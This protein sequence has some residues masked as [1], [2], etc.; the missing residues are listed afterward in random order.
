M[1]FRVN[2]EMCF[3]RQRIEGLCSKILVRIHSDRCTELSNRQLSTTQYIIKIEMTTQYIIKIKMKFQCTAFS[4]LFWLSNIGSSLKRN[5]RSQRSLAVNRKQRELQTR[6]KWLEFPYICL[7]L[8][9]CLSCRCRPWLCDSFRYQE[10]CIM[11]IDWVWEDSTKYFLLLLTCLPVSQPI[12]LRDSLGKI[13]TGDV[14]LHTF[15]WKI[16]S[17]RI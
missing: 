17:G 14:T 9:K 16:V 2:F 1:H 5:H 10:I 4:R 3:K 13:W 6:R 8:W 12:R 15:L 11:A 7:N